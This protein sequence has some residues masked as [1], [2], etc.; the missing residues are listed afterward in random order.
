MRKI[1]FLCIV[2]LEI[3]TIS[4]LA[5]KI[6][7]ERSQVLGE[8]VSI[9]PISKDDVIFPNKDDDSGLKYFYEPMPNTEITYK[10]AWLPQDYTYIATIN[11]D[12]LNERFNYSIDKNSNV[13]RIVTIGD[14]YTFGDNVNTKDN[15]P[16]KLE[17]MLNDNSLC[18]ANMKFE[19]INLG[20]SGYDIEYAVQRFKVR[21]Q[22][23]N[24]DLVLWLI[25]NDDFSDVNELTKP[26]TDQYRVEISADQAL[27]A[28]FQKQGNFYPWA[29]KA[30]QELKEEL[31]R[32]GILT[33]IE[34]SF[35]KIN[36]YYIGRLVFV[37]SSS[38]LKDAYISMLNDFAKERGN[39][40][41][42]D[43]LSMSYDKLEDKAHPT[44]NG[45]VQIAG[46][47]FEYLKKSDLVSCDSL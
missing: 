35:E 20:F 10:A 34:K 3:A 45:Y 17:D 37:A 11:A 39:T 44:S 28:K 33:Y 38:S 5:G 15:Y 36:D 21:G 31:G 12:S 40:Y 41:V 7:L 18:N 43:G 14:S 16:E 19:I 30:S 13:F 6:Y 4:F 26:K 2:I 29:T 25:K 27:L 8:N 9:N 24:P 23:Y 47:I 42:Y 22:K 32:E 46:E 1:V